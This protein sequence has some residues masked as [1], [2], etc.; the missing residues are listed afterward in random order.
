M[1][2]FAID[3]PTKPEERIAFFRTMMAPNKRLITEIYS[4][5]YEYV[6]GPKNKEQKRLEEWIMRYDRIMGFTPDVLSLCNEIGV[7]S[8][9]GDPRVELYS[10]FKYIIGKLA[11]SKND[12]LEITPN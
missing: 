6:K 5:T 8:I 10:H 3:L 9:S 2:T 4:T 7:K 1:D 12:R 11:H